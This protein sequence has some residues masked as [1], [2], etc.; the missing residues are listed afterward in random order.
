MPRF[1]RIFVGVLLSAI[2]VAVVALAIIMGATGGTR[3]CEHDA[4]DR[5]VSD[6]WC[7]AKKPGY[8]WEQD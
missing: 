6:S 3:H 2:L 8:E 7:R 1:L 4:T 5:T